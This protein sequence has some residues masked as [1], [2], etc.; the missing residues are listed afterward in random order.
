MKRAST[1][2]D[3]IC[4]RSVKSVTPRNESLN[5]LTVIGILQKFKPSAVEIPRFA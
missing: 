5:Q 3:P 2:F 1:G 4:C